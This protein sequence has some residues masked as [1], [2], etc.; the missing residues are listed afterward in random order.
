M[1]YNLIETTILLI[2]LNMNKGKKITFGK[3][4]SNFGQNSTVIEPTGS[5]GTFGPSKPVQIES[6]EDDSEHQEMK[7]IMGIASFG[8]K[9]KSFDIHVSLVLII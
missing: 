6:L 9:A 8:K 1:N 3:I 4:S 7:Q 5:F 2:I